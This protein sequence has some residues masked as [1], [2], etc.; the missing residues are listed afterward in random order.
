MLRLS[1][2]FIPSFNWGVTPLDIISLD[3]ENFALYLLDVCGHGVGAALLSISISNIIHS[4]ALID[5][6]FLDPS[7]VQ[8]A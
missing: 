8:A 5:T 1:W 7:V 3:G 6:D 2:R 4:R